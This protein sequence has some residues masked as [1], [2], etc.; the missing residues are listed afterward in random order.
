MKVF[1]ISSDLADIF[2]VPHFLFPVQGVDGEDGSSEDKK[3]LQGAVPAIA[4]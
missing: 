3:V 1:I 4:V 2:Y